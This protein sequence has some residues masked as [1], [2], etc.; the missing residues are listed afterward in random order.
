MVIVAF[1][2]E[3]IMGNWG[4]FDSLVTLQDLD[5]EEP[6]FETPALE[7]VEVVAENE[8]FAA[9]LDEVMMAS[10]G[11]DLAY[12]EMLLMAEANALMVAEMA[13]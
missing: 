13:S 9:V 8:S 2:A 6:P 1:A 4:N 10:A 5:T 7:S 3:V 12:A 11:A